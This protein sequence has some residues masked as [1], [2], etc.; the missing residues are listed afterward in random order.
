[1]GRY[2]SLIGAWLCIML[3]GC[4]AG[5][6]PVGN[7][8]GPSGP[9]DVVKRLYDVCNAGEYSKATGLLSTGLQKS[10]D[11]GLG[12]I[13]GGIKGACDKSTRNGTM[14][15]VEIKS[16]ETRGEGAI[17]IANIHF[18]DGSTTPGDRTE[19]IKE[20]GAWRIAK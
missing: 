8:L 12:A 4:S 2:V 19:L 1:M 16:E 5:V 13:T 6:N 18:K 11:G 7:A 9:S 14:T 17:V 20:N 15:S 10:L 3:Y